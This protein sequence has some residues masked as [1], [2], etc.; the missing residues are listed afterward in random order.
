MEKHLAELQ[1][2]NTE[3]DKVRQET[4]IDFETRMAGLDAEIKRLR[5]VNSALE[6][7]NQENERLLEKQINRTTELG[8]ENMLLN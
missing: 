8:T 3:I 5:E 2:K 1:A 6:G 4:A 7:E